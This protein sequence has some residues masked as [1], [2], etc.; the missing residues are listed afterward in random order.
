MFSTLYPNQLRL[1]SFLHQLGREREQNR[2][3][4]GGDKKSVRESPKSSPPNF[5]APKI[6]HYLIF[7]PPVPLEFNTFSQFEVLLP[8]IIIRS[9]TLGLPLPPQLLIDR[10]FLCLYPSWLAA[11]SPPSLLPPPVTFSPRRKGCTCTLPLCNN[12]I[13]PTHPASIVTHSLLR[14][15]ESSHHGFVREQASPSSSARPR[16]LHLLLLRPRR[17][18]WRH[19]R[20][21]QDVLRGRRRRKQPSGRRCRREQQR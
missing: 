17:P 18:S 10:L 19:R 9:P 14:I 12:D 15:A 1:L 4:F 3:H 5:L 11:L 21:R 2:E 7:D 8:T 16:L 6:K 13:N 20:R